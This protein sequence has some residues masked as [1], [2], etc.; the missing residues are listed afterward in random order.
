MSNLL[1]LLSRSTSKDYVKWENP[2]NSLKYYTQGADEVFYM[3]I[4]ASLY[5]R[6]ILYEPM[7]QRR[8]NCL[9]P[10]PLGGGCA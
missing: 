10:L 1:M 2:G 4:V 9:F 7:K 5:Q 6:D 3:D 8:K